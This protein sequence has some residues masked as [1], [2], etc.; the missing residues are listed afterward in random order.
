MRASYEESRNQ[1][2]VQDCFDRFNALITSLNNLHF[3]PHDWNAYGSP[4]PTK[5]SIED[6]RNILR[7]LWTGNLLPDRVLP[8]ADGGVSF[9]FR[10]DTENRA[11]IET[12]NE[13]ETYVL[14]YDRRGNSKTLPWNE[15][16]P[17]QTKILSQLHLHI[18]GAPLARS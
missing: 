9:L 15:T 4:A 12:L 3:V 14:L 7:S 5:M 17:E 18:Q 10:T 16:A 2:R 8:S 1:S 13:H 11:V 6:A